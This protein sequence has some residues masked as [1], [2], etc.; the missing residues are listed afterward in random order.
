[1]SGVFSAPGV[2]SDSGP[3]D[4]ANAI[5]DLT[6]GPTVRYVDEEEIERALR[7]LNSADA[8]FTANVRSIVLARMGLGG[9]PVPMARVFFEDVSPLKGGASGDNYLYR[10]SPDRIKVYENRKVI[11]ALSRSKTDSQSFFITEIFP[12]EKALLD[13]FY[14]AAPAGEPCGETAGTCSE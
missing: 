13:A 10:A 1:M 11:A 8:V 2:R 14:A 5:R 6:Q 4:T 3:F 7:V 12:A 9:P